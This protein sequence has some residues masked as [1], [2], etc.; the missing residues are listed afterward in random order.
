MSTETM[1]NKHAEVRFVRHRR[2]CHVLHESIALAQV[3]NLFVLSLSLW[4]W[5]KF[6][7]E[8]ANQDPAFAEQL[9]RD[10]LK[11]REENEALQDEVA[12]VK[13]MEQEA[14]QALRQARGISSYLK[15]KQ[16]ELQKTSTEAQLALR[17]ANGISSYLKS[18]NETLEA[19]LEDAERI[20][21]EAQQ[22]LRQARGISAYLQSKNV[23]LEKKLAAARTEK[24]AQLNFHEARNNSLLL[25]NSITE[26]DLL[27][28]DFLPDDGDARSE[29]SEEQPS[30]VSSDDD[31]VE[32]PGLE[33]P[34]SNVKVDEGP[35]DG[36]TVNDAVGMIGLVF[37]GLI[38]CMR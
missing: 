3:P 12:A 15:G 11:L 25:K 5:R 8:R 7:I 10:L 37:V 21:G 32:Q 31:E 4:Y 33:V 18:K 36:L 38:I 1:E 14:Y 34:K 29:H 30:M 35:A 16:G 28:S 23:S 2:P 9:V 6:M 17:Q 13:R 26:T 22:A 24:S 20:E 19:K 27:H